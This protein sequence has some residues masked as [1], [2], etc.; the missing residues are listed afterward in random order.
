[1]LNPVSGEVS[2]E[3]MAEIFPPIVRVKVKDAF[4]S[5]SFCQGTKVLKETELFA[6][7]FQEIDAS[8]ASGLVG[9]RDH[10]AVTRRGEGCN[11]TDEIR[12]NM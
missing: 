12:L 7:L 9:I 11:R 4:T 6:L 10:I 5:F 2:L 8:K 1:M 3:V